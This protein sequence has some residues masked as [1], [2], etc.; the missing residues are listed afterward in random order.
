MEDLILR[1]TEQVDDLQEPEDLIDCLLTNSDLPP[2]AS[3]TLP[4]IV[5]AVRALALRYNIPVTTAHAIVGE[6]MHQIAMN[7]DERHLYVVYT[8]Q[9]NEHGDVV[10]ESAFVTDSPLRA[11]AYVVMK[12]PELQNNEESWN[13]TDIWY[14]QIKPDTTYAHGMHTLPAEPVLRDAVQHMIEEN[15]VDLQDV[16]EVGDE[17]PDFIA[18]MDIERD[19]VGGWGSTDIVYRI[20]TSVFPGAQFRVYGKLNRDYQEHEGLVNADQV[21]L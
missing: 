11:S 4:S 17:Q 5:A 6:G 14:V 10:V 1:C 9:T 2:V 21:Q 13:L 15:G 7:N 3:Y 16:I 19:E 8:E 12:E 20:G 18:S